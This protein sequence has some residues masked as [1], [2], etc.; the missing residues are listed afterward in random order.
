[1]MIWR[2]RSGEPLL[3]FKGHGDKGFNCVAWSPDG[4]LVASGD[5]D[6]A[7]LV[8]KADTGT[9]VTLPLRGHGE[10]VSCVCFGNKTRSLI[11]SGSEDRTIKIWE[12]G[13]RGDATLRRTLEGHTGC[14]WSIAL[15]PDDRYI[16]SASDD[17]TV[18]LWD[19]AT[20][21]R[22]RVLEGHMGM[23]SRV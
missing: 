4:E 16:A 7:I 14:V 10:S 2:A 8:W 22:I 17:K 9:Q 13:E 11:V 6:R 3:T 12:L 19:V 23:G 18:G 21:Q 15:S 1:V 20:G 5:D